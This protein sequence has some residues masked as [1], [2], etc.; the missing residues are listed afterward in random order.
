M[1]IP[2]RLKVSKFDPGRLNADKGL[3]ILGYFILIMGKRGSGKTSVALD[4]MYYL[5]GHVDYA[6]A[7][8]ATASVSNV[9][10][11][12][13]PPVFVHKSGSPE[14]ISKLMTTQRKFIEQGSPKRMVLFID[15]MA[16]DKKFL[17]SEEFSELIF[18]GRWYNVTVILTTQYSK[19]MPP[20]IRTNVDL[21]ITM[22]QTNIIVKRAMYEEFF[23]IVTS[24][25]FDKIM[26]QTTKNFQALVF[27]NRTQ[28]DNL[29]EVLFWFKAN[30]AHLEPGKIKL[31]KPSFW[32]LRMPRAGSLRT[33]SASHIAIGDQVGPVSMADIDGQTIISAPKPRKRRARGAS[34]QVT[35]HAKA[36]SSIKTTG[37]FPGQSTHGVLDDIL[38]MPDDGVFHSE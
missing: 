24:K 2:K 10:K 12:I 9:L 20:G 6:I 23:G 37:R 5:Q 17:A 15:D 18:N 1:N 22:K 38:E 34:S 8:S 13:I 26:A 30:L 11:S 32:A 14:F 33:P 35:S 19:A 25:D 29:D 27:D 36:T 3:K 4:F 28:A 31:V 21:C 7:I 16:F